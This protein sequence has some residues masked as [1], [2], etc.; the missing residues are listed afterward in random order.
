MVASK[1]SG[2][3]QIRQNGRCIHVA[4]EPV[5][6]VSTLERCDHADE[7]RSRVAHG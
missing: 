6:C 7:A 3:Q 5:S 2:N 1:E 4:F